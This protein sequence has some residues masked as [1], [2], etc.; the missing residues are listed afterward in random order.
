[1]GRVNFLL[2][3]GAVIAAGLS[4]A[5]LLAPAAFYAG[6]G[7]AVGS[8]VALLNELK[9][10]AGAILLAA[11]VMAT[12]LARPDWWDR[13]LLVGTLLYLGF[14]VG[15]LA[16]LATDGLPPVSLLAVMAAELLLG[17]GFAYAFWRRR[18]R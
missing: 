12:A 2:A 14:G 9:A 8:D 4:L 15:R 13:A 11:V 5:I 3:L 17:L 1:M 10:P 18:P 6:Y 16:A 7:I